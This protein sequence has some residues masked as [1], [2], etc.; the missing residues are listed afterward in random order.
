MW[1]NL[2]K[3]LRKATEVQAT[4][5]AQPV[6]GEETPTQVYIRLRSGRLLFSSGYAWIR[7]PLL[8]P[9][10]NKTGSLVVLCASSFH[11]LVE[12]DRF[13]WASLVYRI[14]YRSELHPV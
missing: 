3:L 8:W 14:Y 7:L 5:L 4:H 11:L 6:W 10:K 1:N 2:K 9:F 13:L 12:A